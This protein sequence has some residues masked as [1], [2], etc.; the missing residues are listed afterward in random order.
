MFAWV[1]VRDGER[2]VV[3]MRKKEKCVVGI[4]RHMCTNVQQ[5]GVLGDAVVYFY[6]AAVGHG[7]IRHYSF[8]FNTM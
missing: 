1:D 2:G 8:S 5:G 3:R 7:K 6:F 4:L